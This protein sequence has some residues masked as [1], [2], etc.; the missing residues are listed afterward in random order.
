MSAAPPQDCADASSVLR[1][2]F[3]NAERSAGARVMALLQMLADHAHH[4]DRYGEFVR[5]ADRDE[6]FGHDGGRKYEPRQ[7]S[8]HDAPDT[9]RRCR[10]DNAE[11]SGG[12]VLRKRN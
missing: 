6:K 5:K 10:L 12:Q 4:D 9:P 8:E 3:G 2:R 1:S 7:R 11:V